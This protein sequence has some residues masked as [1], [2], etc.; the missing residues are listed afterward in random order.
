MDAIV[1][2][3]VPPSV[4]LSIW[5]P[6]NN[7]P[8]RLDGAFQ[9]RSISDDETAVA[10]RFVGGLGGPGRIC[11]FTEYRFPNDGDIKRTKITTVTK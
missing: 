7:K 5:Y 4:D 11:A 8:P 9:L 6:D 3:V 2:Q 1:L 10:V